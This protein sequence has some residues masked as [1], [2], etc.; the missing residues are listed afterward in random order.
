MS[1][2]KKNYEKFGSRNFVPSTAGAN[3]DGEGDI[4][5]IGTGHEGEDVGAGQIYYMA[6]DGNGGV[7]WLITDADAESTSKNLLAVAMASGQPSDVGMLL[8][9]MVTLRNAPGVGA[10]I[11]LFLSTTA[12]ACNRVAP[13][14]T[15]DV[16]RVI[17]YNI[18]DTA[19]AQIWFNPDSTYI[20]I[21]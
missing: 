19:N 14:A 8:R 9:G 10:G 3:G 12:G 20:V 5:F 2:P 1:T 7:E 6:T 21:A 11:P 18:N 15:G 17:G 4:I 16:V 13:S